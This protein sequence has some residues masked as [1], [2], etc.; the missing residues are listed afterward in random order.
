MGDLLPVGRSI[1]EGMEYSNCGKTGIRKW[2]QGQSGISC[3]GEYFDT[4]IASTDYNRVGTSVNGPYGEPPT[5]VEVDIID[6]YTKQPAKYAY[7]PHA[8]QTSYQKALNDQLIKVIT[9][10]IAQNPW[11]PLGLWSDYRRLGLPF[12]ENMV[13]ENPLTACR[14]DKSQCQHNLQPNFFPQRLNILL[15]LRTA[16]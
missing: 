11:L 6:G 2:Y 8:S 12:F 7:I 13:V 1:T 15:R 16:T 3:V 14:P 10:F 9:Q 4:Y 5:T